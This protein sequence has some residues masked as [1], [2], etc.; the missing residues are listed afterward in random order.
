[1]AAP[2]TTANSFGY[3]PSVDEKGLAVMDRYFGANFPVVKGPSD[4]RVSIVTGS[5]RTISI[6]PGEGY[7]HFVLDRTLVAHTIGLA[8]AA[9]ADRWDLITVRRDWSPETPGGETS[10]HVLPGAATGAVANPRPTG[11][12]NTPGVLADQPLALV[13]IRA[14]QPLPQ[15]II[16]LRQYASKVNTA[17]HTLALEPDAPVG[18]LTRIG[19]LTYLRALDAQGA[20]QWGVEGAWADYVPVWSSTTGATSVGT[21]GQLVGRYVRLGRTVHWQMRWFL[22]SPS[23]GGTGDGMWYFT[24]PLPASTPNL[25]MNAVANVMM[26]NR[27]VWLSGMAHRH[28]AIPG[29]FTVIAHNAARE[30]GPLNPNSLGWLAGDEMR[31]SGTYE[32]EA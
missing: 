6:A 23:A 3:G 25:S 22:G 17:S 29:A 4:W 26:K 5:T 31:I 2:F 10:F 8:A 28:Q 7:G 20:P 11:F 18:A 19:P 32:V 12:A 1:M 16:D 21:G 30:I 27:G 14:N 15:E 9:S 24:L 13:R